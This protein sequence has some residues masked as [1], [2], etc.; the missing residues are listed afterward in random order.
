MVESPELWR[1]APTRYP[2]PTGIRSIQTE[3]AG[4][5]SP[6]VQHHP[7]TTGVRCQPES[8]HGAD[9]FVTDPAERKIGDARKKHAKDV[10]PGHNRRV[11]FGRETPGR[12][13]GKAKW[14]GVN[15]RR[16]PISGST[17]PA[18]PQPGMA[19]PW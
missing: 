3:T 8:S 18:S 17:D 13:I 2:L 10:T 5:L 12:R 11:F 7:T 14:H 19:E 4:A 1:P 6:V 16:V 15:S 9:S